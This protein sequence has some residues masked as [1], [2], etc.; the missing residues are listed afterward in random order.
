MSF[1][2]CIQSCNQHHN[3]NVEYF[4]Q[5]KSPPSASLQKRLEKNVILSAPSWAQREK[6]ELS[7]MGLQNTRQ[8]DSPEEEEWGWRVK[9]LHEVILQSY[10]HAKISP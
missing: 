1:G 8:L 6:P 4:H 9:L 7:S 10:L 3:K 2:K 5:P